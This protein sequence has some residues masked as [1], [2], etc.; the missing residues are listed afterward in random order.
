[1]YKQLN[2]N[3]PLIDA[4]M[5]Y[6]S[7]EARA[8][9]LRDRASHGKLLLGEDGNLPRNSRGLPNNGGADRTD[10]FIAGDIRSNEQ[11]ALTAMHLLWTKEH[12]W[13]VGCLCTRGPPEPRLPA[14]T[15]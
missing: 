15:F 3:T 6:G 14:L 1:M 5:I 9:V 11:A 7:D 13:W 10:L 2:S 4:S 8:R 12:N